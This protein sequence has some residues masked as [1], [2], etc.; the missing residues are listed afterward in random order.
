MSTTTPTA[1]DTQLA[2]HDIT[3]DR[4]TG[5]VV[6]GVDITIPPGEVTALMGPNGAGKS[7]LVL[8]IGG[9]LKAHGSVKLANRELLNKRPERIRQ[10]GI[11]IVPEG[12]RLLPELT[13]ADN[14]QVAC[15]AL[16][17][18]DAKAGVAHALELFPELEKRMN[19]PARSLSGGEQ[20]MLVLA[21][22]LVS[23]PTFML[24]DELSLGLA[25]VVVKRLIPTIRTI[26]ETGVGVL[27]IEQ[28]ATVAL[29][30]ANHAYIMDRGRIR[31][32]GTADELKNNPEL[33]QTS[34]L[35]SGE[36]AQ[37]GRSS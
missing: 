27:L 10:A 15:Y 9:V 26:A 8:A 35:L 22:A 14:L 18:T 21:Q 33:L 11:A 36:A 12:R 19:L 37:P 7:S 32:T 5:P 29:E 24:I 3:V 31:Y 6:R 28:F 1:T 34:Y 16:S 2:L 30:L 23:A 4:G 20:Q 17:S 25:P 13:V